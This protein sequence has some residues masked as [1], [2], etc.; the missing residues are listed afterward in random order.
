MS[1]GKIFDVPIWVWVVIIIVILISYFTNNASCSNI[2]S[3]A[4]VEPENDSKIKIYNFN[5]RWCGYSKM[6]QP[7]WDKFQNAIR[8][9]QVSNIH[10]YDVKCDDASNQ[11]MCNS[12]DVPGYPS[13]IAEVNGKRIPYDGPR[14]SSKLIEFAQS[15][16]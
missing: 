11:S 2:S 1:D 12:Y 3:F 9:N 5:T 8:N 7:E 10:V 13:V 15:L 4:N 14:E 16:K 6:F